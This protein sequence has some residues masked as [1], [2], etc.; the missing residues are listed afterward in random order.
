MK[1]K[2]MTDKY[3]EELKARDK[4]M[5]VKRYT[6]KTRKQPDDPICPKC[7]EIRFIVSD[8]Y[9]F[10]PYCGQRLDMSNWEL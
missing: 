10:C 9:Q 4:A 8:E 3:I 5:P 7:G 2:T 1:G 6:W